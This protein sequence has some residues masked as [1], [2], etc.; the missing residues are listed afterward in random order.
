[1]PRI[2]LHRSVGPRRRAS[3]SGSVF[4]GLAVAA[5]STRLL[6]PAHAAE[7]VGPAATDATAA[8]VE[9][10]AQAGGQPAPAQLAPVI[11]TSQKRVETL[12]SVPLSINVTDA[13]SLQK[14]GAQNFTD[15]ISTVPSLSSFQTGPGRSQLIIRGV[16]TGGVTEDDPQTQET[17]GLYVDDSA[18]SVNGF[19]PEYGFFDLERVE[20]LRGPQGTLYGGGA[21][22][23][24]VKLVTRKPNL[25][26]FGGSIEGDLS[27]VHSG[28]R[29]NDARAVLNVPLVEGTAAVRASVFH[30]R[31]GGY[32]DNSATGERDLNHSATNG[33]R[34]A[35][36]I[37]PSE[38]LTVDLSY[39][40]QATKDGGRPIDEGNL[41]RSYLSPEGS[42][43]QYQLLNATIAVDV[44]FADLVS[45]SSGLKFD[46]T[47][48]RQLDK[49]LATLTTDLRGALAD[50]THLKDF[51]Q[52]VRLASKDEGGPLKWLAGIY[53]NHRQRDYVNQFPVPGWDAEFPQSASAQF[54]APGDSPFFGFD[55]VDVTQSALFGE[56]T[57]TLGAFGFTAGLRAF[58]WR[59]DFYLYSS[60]AF[61]GGVTTTGQRETT[62]NGTTPKFNATWQVDKNNLVYVQA[63]KGFR[64]G[65]INQIVPL[66]LCAKELADNNLAVPSPTYNP[67]SLWNYEI[68]NK[69]TLLDGRLTLNASVYLIKWKDIQVNRG[70]NCG[71]SFR[72]NAAGLTSK[73]FEIETTVRPVQ[74]LTFTVGGSYTD[75]TLDQDV[76]DLSAN[77]GDRAPFVPRLSL[78]ST[79]EYRFPVMAGTDAFVWAAYQHVG[80]RAT[81]FNPTLQRYRTM[82]GYNVVNARVGAER[83]PFEVSLYVKNLTDSRGIQRALASTPFDSEGAYR[84]TPR[85]IGVTGRY[86]F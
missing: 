30:D 47:N 13:Q 60:G 84:I 32:I 5:L 61:N 77:K 86:T 26:R 36:R 69:S 12:Q 51:T 34:I 31:F 9:R 70:L 52:E 21:M 85:T 43:S 48:R 54:G 3:L 65:G 45:S 68:G 1:M 4:T 80:G 16:T 82:G 53:F 29:G 42:N 20:V 71:F 2:H 79:A 46:I 15:L 81:D 25:Y 11:V 18:I 35:M 44:G 41:T 8:D 83:G 33:G 55:N 38:R 24:A 78:S 66:N 40:G 19:N 14:M 67:D 17:V 28:G 23:G 73:G 6:Q 63:A 49:T 10:K 75:A 39:F 62:K 72:E 76:P 22:S 74:G 7:A 57:Y 59:E 64:F 27:S 50:Q 37:E 58:H 56:A